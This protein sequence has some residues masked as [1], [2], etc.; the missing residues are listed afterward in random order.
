MGNLFNI[1][2]NNQASVVPGVSFTYPTVQALT[3]YIDIVNNFAWKN[4]GLNTQEVPSVIFTE[5]ELQ[6]GMTVNN[7][8]QTL[9]GPAGAAA[10]F[11]NGGKAD[12]YA[13][14]YF[15]KLTGFQYG[16]PYLLKS[17]S[18]I[19]GSIKNKW[20]PVPDLNKTMTRNASK[21][22][23]AT[24][25]KIGKGFKN[26]GSMFET[27]GNIVSPGYGQEPVYK[28]DGTTPRSVAISFPLYNTITLQH[29]ID[30]FNFVNLFALQNLKTRTSYTSYIP[31]K[32]Y[33]VDSLG[34]G[35]LAMPA[36]YISSYDVVSIGTTRAIDIGMGAGGFGQM[37]AITP[38]ALEGKV[39]IPEAY[40]VT[41]VVTELFAESAN[42]LST[43]LGGSPVSVIADP[44]KNISKGGI[45]F[46]NQPKL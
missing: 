33:K 32:I 9:S 36:A 21:N 16:F 13:S 38:Q 1:Q 2:P 4:D 43:A 28:Y 30:N 23:N 19:K 6:Y 44:T 34:L 8:L 20:S 15:G 45:Q 5:Y 46:N 29:T 22:E 14:L 11:F 10:A 27:I 37:Q 31:P 25:R 7:L 3:N 12:P 39:L 40:K 17:G 24:I 35:G 42:T 26:L 41:I 18:S